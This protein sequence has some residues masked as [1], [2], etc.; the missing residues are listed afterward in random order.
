MKDLEIMMFG[1]D[2]T[3]YQTRIPPSPGLTQS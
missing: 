1:A 2:S 3:E